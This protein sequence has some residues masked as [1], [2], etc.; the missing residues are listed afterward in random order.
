VA[1]FIESY[2]NMVISLREYKAQDVE[3]G[4]GRGGVL[5]VN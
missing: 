5:K 3:G 2:N 4:M 1:A